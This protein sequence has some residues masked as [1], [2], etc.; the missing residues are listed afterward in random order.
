[1]GIPRSLDL[2][3]TP[4]WVYRPTPDLWILGGLTQRHSTLDPGST[5]PG[6]MVESCAFWHVVL[7]ALP[8][9]YG[10]G[11]SY[12]CSVGHYPEPVALSSH[13][14]CNPEILWISWV[15]PRLH[16]IPRIHGSRV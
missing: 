12:A 3:M 11:E 5:D 16:P 14:G 6:A 4:S 8:R 7:V 15:L 13:R 9:S 1:M 2:R 10:P